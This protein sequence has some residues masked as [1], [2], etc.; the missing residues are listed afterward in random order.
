MM[1]RQLQR[2]NLCDERHGNAIIANILALPVRGS[3]C[4]CCLGSRL[5]ITAIA[6][7]L[8]GLLL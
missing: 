4:L 8:L 7:F 3:T 5:Y 6:F 1:P 2:L